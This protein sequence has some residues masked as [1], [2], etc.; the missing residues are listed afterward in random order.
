MYLNECIFPVAMDRDSVLLMTDL[1]VLAFIVKNYIPPTFSTLNI[2][3]INVR[4]FIF[5]MSE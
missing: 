2:H 3:V 4:M 5:I 1:L